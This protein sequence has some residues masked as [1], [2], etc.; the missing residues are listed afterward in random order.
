MRIWVF[1]LAFA[2]LVPV[3]MAAPTLPPAPSS[4]VYDEAEVLS[5]ATQS[6]LEAEL[7]K[8]DQE[9]STQIVV[10]TVSSLQDYP[11]EDFA[12]E[13]AR[14]WGLGQSEF[15]N[16]LL[17]L[18][19]PNERQ[20]RIEVGY[21]LE[22]AITDAQAF[23]LI[24]NTAIPNFKNNDYDTGVLTTVDTLDSLARGEAFDTSLLSGSK[25]QEGSFMDVIGVF[26][27]MGFFFLMILMSWFSQSKSWWMGGV[28][29]AVLGLM[30]GIVFSW[31]FGLMGILLGAGAGLGIDYVASTFL[32]GKFKNTG[33][34]GGRFG[35]G[36]SGSS[37][38][39]G[40]FGGGSFG[41]GGASGSW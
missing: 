32:F 15:D 18:I 9:N 36:S 37:G 10:A 29:G 23:N 41:G 5:E 19:A 27:F 14:A 11:I 30:V 33:S 25:L 28:V 2:F 21:G 35:G 12:L 6:A 24:Q 8:L 40:G 34:G 17:F 22:G 31:I 3:A 38:G 7:T 13:L 20:A 39:F 4:Y 26:L 16:G 1:S